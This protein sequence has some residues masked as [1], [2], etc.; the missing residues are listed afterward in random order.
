MTVYLDVQH[1]TKWFGERLLFEDVSFS[2]AKGQ[3][4][5]LI[6]RNGTVLAEYG[7][8]A[9]AIFDMVAAKLKPAE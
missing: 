8:K 2:I 6:A 3:H 1:L 4:V 5:A 9:D 7:K